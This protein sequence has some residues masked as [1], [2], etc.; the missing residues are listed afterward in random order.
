MDSNFVPIRHTIFSRRHPISIRSRANAWKYLST[1]TVSYLFFLKWKSTDF[2][3]GWRRNNRIAVPIRLLRGEH[4]IGQGLC[5][6]PGR[7]ALWTSTRSSVNENE[8]QALLP[9]RHH[10]QQQHGSISSSSIDKAMNSNEQH[11]PFLHSIKAQRFSDPY[12]IQWITETPQQLKDTGMYRLSLSLWRSLSIVPFLRQT[13]HLEPLMLCLQ[14]IHRLTQSALPW[15][16]RRDDN[17]Y[18]W[19]LYFWSFV[20]VKSTHALVFIH[21]S[22]P[23]FLNV[24]HYQ[25]RLMKETATINSRTK[26]NNA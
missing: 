22:K 7:S 18:H 6:F 13:N 16:R 23:V 3:R 17:P 5:L 4:K 14:A 10:Q 11:R 21:F 15:A 20:W 19:S 25:R 24:L 26:H 8:P 12:S 9:G 2:F 1:I